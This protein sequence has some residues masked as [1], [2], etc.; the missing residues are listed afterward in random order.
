MLI[1]SQKAT[2]KTLSSPKKQ[3]NVDFMR[4]RDHRDAHFT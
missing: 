3:L 1:S 2:S 4:M